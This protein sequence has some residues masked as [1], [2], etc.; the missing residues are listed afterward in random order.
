M[1]TKNNTLSLILFFSLFFSFS[2]NAINS[3]NTISTDK[4][5][6]VK[7]ITRPMNSNTQGNFVFKE[8]E[9]DTE[10]FA[11]ATFLLVPFYN[12]TC[13]ISKIK[14]LNSDYAYF[15]KAV[16]PINITIRVLRI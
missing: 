15:Q 4:F 6:A 3:I 5:H 8:L 10:D 9:N 1:N 2:L 12:L 14:I 11:N 13:C 7:K 16:K